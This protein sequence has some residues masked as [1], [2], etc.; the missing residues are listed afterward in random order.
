[1]DSE[2]KRVWIPGP[3]IIGAGPSGLAAAACLKQI[4]VPSLILEKESCLASLWKLKTYDSLKLHLAK[5]LCELPHMAIPPGFPAYPTKQQFISYLEA[6]AKHFSITPMFGEEVRWAKYDATMG[7]WQVQAN[8]SEFVCRWLIVA[9]GE[10]AEPVLPEIDGIS[11]FEG[12]LLHTSTYKNGAD[13]KGSNVLVVG[14]GNSGMEISLDLCDNGA[15]VSLVVRDKLHILPRQ[16][17]G[18]STFA[19][20]MWLLKWFPV[21]LV[22][23]FLLLSS[24]MILGD[25]HRIGIKRP[26]IGPLELKNTTGKTPVLDVGAMEK[27]K[28]GEIKVVRGIRRFTTKGAEFVDGK[29]VEFE[30]VILATGYRS[31]VLSWLK[32]GNF[33][34]CKDG[35]PKNPFPNNWKGNNGLYSVGFT[36]RGLLGASIDAQRVAEDIARQWNSKTKHLHLKL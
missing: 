34:S 29:V 7:F 36:R 3:V 26:K 23:W 20:S 25:T 10:N 19:L 12:R 1:M 8:N 27:I 24:R 15:Q 13:F 14:C 2:L 22:D 17:L 11:D 16:V 30:S 35:Y 18:R 32:E 4:G 5:K 31:N 33:F 28:S 9:T 6:Y 21:R